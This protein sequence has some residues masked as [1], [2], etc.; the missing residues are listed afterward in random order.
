M[1]F[2][3]SSLVSKAP[4]YHFS[5]IQKKNM[6]RGVAGA[7]L[8]FFCWNADP[9]PRK[10]RLATTTRIPKHHLLHQPQDDYITA[11]WCSTPTLLLICSSFSRE[12]GQPLL[13]CSSLS[14]AQT[15]VHV[16][17]LSAAILITGMLSHIPPPSRMVP[18]FQL[19][20]FKKYF[21]KVTKC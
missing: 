21:R 20:G 13:V 18:N 9:H 14:T 19:K 12:N 2:I 1:S 4:L 3:R 8:I 7:A 15:G 17:M 10:T 11:G 16:C 5:G 6:F